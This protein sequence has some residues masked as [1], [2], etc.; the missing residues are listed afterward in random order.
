MTDIERYAHEEEE[1]LARQ[2]HEAQREPVAKCQTLSYAIGKEPYPFYEWD[3]LPE[4]AKEGR[5]MQARY[6]ISMY[7]IIP[8]LVGEEK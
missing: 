7:H 2:I 8:K 3:E 6:L 4:C 5:R 1:G